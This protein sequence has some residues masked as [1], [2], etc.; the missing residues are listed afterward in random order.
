MPIISPSRQ[1][2]HWSFL[3]LKG[4]GRILTSVALQVA[5]L[6]TGILGGILVGDEAIRN[7]REKDV[8][9]S[10]EFL[11]VLE[12]GNRCLAWWLP[13]ASLGCCWWKFL[14]REREA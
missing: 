2:S 12:G 13:F 1:S 9:K 11:I 4:L 10:W 14:V 3:G 5:H 6:P 7:C 8:G